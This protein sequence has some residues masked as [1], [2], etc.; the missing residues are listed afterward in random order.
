MDSILPAVLTG[1]AAGVGIVALFGFVGGFGIIPPIP[2]DT[3]G[4]VITLERTA[5]F[6]VCPDYAVTIYGNGSVI[7]NGRHLVP[8]TGIRTSQISEESVRILVTE[9]YRIGYFSLNDKYTA[10]VTDLP[11]TIT[12][13]TVSG[14]TKK[15][16]DYYGAPGSLK[17]L[18]EKIDSTVGTDKWVKCP[19][20]Q[21]VDYEKGGCKV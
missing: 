6:G 18:E 19:P 8:V 20:G 13:I 17:S 15:V 10:P 11:T 7:Y 9:F 4:V 2:A 14:S 1:L 16:I 3:H 12:S 21:Q 5:C